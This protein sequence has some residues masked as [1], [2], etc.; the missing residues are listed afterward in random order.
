MLPWGPTRAGQGL[1]QKV[2]CKGG[3]GSPWMIHRSPGRGIKRG[4]L[5]NPPGVG[6]PYLFLCI[7]VIEA[8]SLLINVSSSRARSWRLST[9][10]THAI[11]P[12][13]AQGGALGIRMP[14]GQ[15]GPHW[16]GSAPTMGPFLGAAVMLCLAQ[17]SQ[18]SVRARDWLQSHHLSQGSFPGYMLAGPPLWPK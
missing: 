4:P 9:G 1:E 15:Q 8:F 2:Q 11:L 5:L 13:A 6:R 10:K 18:D 3:A 17:E 14:S 12:G 16:E 7:S